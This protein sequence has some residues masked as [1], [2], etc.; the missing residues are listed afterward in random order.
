MAFN[1]INMNTWNRRYCFN[2][3]VQNNI[4]KTETQL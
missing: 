1:I 4:K 3:L 2:H